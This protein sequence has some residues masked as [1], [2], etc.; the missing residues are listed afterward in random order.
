[1]NV[2]E[3]RRAARQDRYERLFSSTALGAAGLIIMPALLVNPGAL[4]RA[5]QFLYFWFLSWLAGKKNHPLRIVLALLVI[6]LFNL[7]IPYGRLILSLG[8][9]P[10]TAG[11]L[12]QGIRRAVT[13]EG[14]IMASRL[15]IRPDL[16]LPGAFG[17][18]I[19]ESFRVF[20]QIMARTKPVDPKDIVGSID[21]LLIELSGNLP[22]GGTEA[23]PAK[24]RAARGYLVLAAALLLAWAPAVFSALTAASEAVY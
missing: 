18:L 16:R 21:D 11:A 3:Q 1:M 9:F 10:I 15:T 19:G 20:G 7:I 6:I 2:R 22:P 12:N 24:R 14:L 8:P 17:E 13:L 4:S 23:P 5:A